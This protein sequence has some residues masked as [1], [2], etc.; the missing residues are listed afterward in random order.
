MGNFNSYIP[1]LNK[2]LLRDYS[3]NKLSISKSAIDLI[4]TLTPYIDRDGTLH[5]DLVHVRK[6]MK[7]D[8]RTLKRIL[9]ELFNT[10]YKGKELLTY[11]NGYYVSH[12][13]V[14]SNGESTYQKHLEVLHSPEVRNLSKNQSRLFYYILTSNVYNQR[15]RI[16]IENLYKNKLHD[17]K[18]GL[19]IYDDY[20]SLTEDLFK[21]LEL[22]LISVTL[23]GEESNNYVDVK[24]NGY[25]KKFHHIFG[26]KNDKK[27]RTSKYLKKK[28]VIGLKI[29]AKHFDKKPIGNKAGEEEIR[30]LANRSLFFYEDMSEDTIN[31]FISKKNELM[32]KFGT[33]GLEIYRVTL[34]KYFKDKKE[35]IIYYDLIGKAVNYFNDFYLLEEIKDVILGSI[36]SE[37]KETGKE[38]SYISLDLPALIRYFITYSSDE[39]KVLLDQDIQLIQ[40]AYDVIFSSSEDNHWNELQESIQSVFDKHGTAIRDAFISE[41]E[42][43]DITPSPSMLSDEEVREVIVSNAKNHILS[44]KQSIEEATRKSKEV[45]RFFRK[46]TYSRKKTSPLDT[47]QK[48]TQLN[49][50]ISNNNVYYNWLEDL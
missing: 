22:G 30:L 47:T 34:N 12:F 15:T 24:E 35:S 7:W 21:L 3:T 45:I 27:Q 9:F 17:L 28:H 14:S 20:K 49:K 40:Y 39:H 26:Y 18:C 48:A 41:C 8:R 13:H 23:P 36:R 31:L 43:N 16:Y 37:T 19:T 10:R 46:K 50:K 2:G 38:S 32:E 29:N 11:E 42:M 25:Q 44:K 5:I 4:V 1:K 6:L 33:A